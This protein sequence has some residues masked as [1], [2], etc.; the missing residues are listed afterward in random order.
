MKQA[1]VADRGLGQHERFETIRCSQGGEPGVADA[2][3]AEV[4]LTRGRIR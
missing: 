4:E 2:R 1:G 3:V